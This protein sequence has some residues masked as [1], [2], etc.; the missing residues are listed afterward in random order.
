[1]LES[2]GSLGA[3]P[4]LT[5]LMSRDPR[6]RRLWRLWRELR[7]VPFVAFD[8]PALWLPLHD[9]P[10]LY[11]QWCALAVVRAALPLGAVVEQRLI[12]ADDDG[13]ERRWTLRLRRD[14]PL[15]TLRRADGAC[16]AVRYQP[17]YEPGRRESLG[18]IDPY[19]RVPDIAIEVTHGDRTRALIFDAKYRVD[20]H[21]RPPQDALDD[22]YTYRGAIGVGGARATLGAFLLFPGTARLA[23]AD[24]V[25]AIP[26]LPGDHHELAS[27]IARLTHG[28]P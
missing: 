8:S 2:I 6:Y 17:R 1:L 28:A 19:V 18:A 13:P 3:A 5:Q 21:G 4:R 26:L 9:L 25:G 7:S 27:L 14:V 20:D 16:I 10:T 24:E 22:A 12:E 15:L 23:I 11:E